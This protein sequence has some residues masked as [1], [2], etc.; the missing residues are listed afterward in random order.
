VT[1]RR[2]LGYAAALPVSA[3][4]A[5]ALPLVAATGGR[6]RMRDGVIEAAGGVLGP[7]LTR[8]NP[9]FPIDAITLG[10]V[11]LAVDTRAL[12]S[13]RRHERVHV[14]QYERFGA[15]FPFLYLGASLVAMWRGG[16]AYRDNAFE[17]EARALSAETLAA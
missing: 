15:L 17:R 14:R 7:L 4:A 9:R 1:L 5:A 6:V 11:V 16:G 8:G 2:A 3:V 13:T 10:H 12:E